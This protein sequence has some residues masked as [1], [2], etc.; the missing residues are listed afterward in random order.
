MASKK[1]KRRLAR[2]ALRLLSSA[3][4]RYRFADCELDARLYQLRRDGTPVAIEPR[5]FDVLVF[6]LHQRDRIVSKDEL[7]DKLWPGQ[8]VTETALTRC[9]VAARKAVGGDGTNYPFW[10]ANYLTTLG[11]SYRLLGQYDKAID[12]LKQSLNLHPTGG[13][14]LWL[15]ATYSEAGQDFLAQ[16]LATEILKAAPLFSLDILQSRILYQDPAKTEHFLAALR[17]AGLK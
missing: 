4:M 11:D 13:A 17:K 5:V 2:S 1:R 8:V 6:L 16:A 7:L 12:T 15:T 3:P 9:I 14:A 10:T